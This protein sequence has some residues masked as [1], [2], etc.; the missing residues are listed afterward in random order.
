LNRKFGYS[1][2]ISFI[3]SGALTMLPL[4]AMA[5]FFSQYFSK[6]GWVLFIKDW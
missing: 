6:I 1:S 3:I 5:I 4:N 2:F